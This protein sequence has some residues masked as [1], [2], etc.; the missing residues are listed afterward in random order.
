MLT[1]SF[2][3]AYVIPKPPFPCYL[4]E[5]GDKEIRYLTQAKFVQFFFLQDGREREEG[6]E[7]KDGGPEREIVQFE[8]SNLLSKEMKRG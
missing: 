6:G 5:N 4:S 3:D 1:T 8:N 2:L 7:E